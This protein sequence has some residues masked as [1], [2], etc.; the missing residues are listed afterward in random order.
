[1]LSESNRLLFSLGQ[2][3]KQ[4]VEIPRFENVCRRRLFRYNLRTDPCSYVN[5]L[6]FLVFQNQLADVE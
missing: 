4:A 5:R 2:F 3:S 6:D 1:M